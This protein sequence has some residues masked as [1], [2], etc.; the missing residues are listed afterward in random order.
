MPPAVSHDTAVMASG[1]NIC[2]KLGYQFKMDSV[3]G[4][5][6]QDTAVSLESS[7]SGYGYEFTA[8]FN[9]GNIP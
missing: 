1:H 5:K 9:I 6:V 8:F 4:F 2:F 3:I 7:V